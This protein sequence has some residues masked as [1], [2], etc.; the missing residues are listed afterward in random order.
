MQSPWEPHPDG[1]GQPSLQL[2]GST[3]QLQTDCL[4]PRIDCEQ[5]IYLQGTMTWIFRATLNA[6]KSFTMVR[7]VR[8]KCS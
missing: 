7:D 6:S 8:L 4:I 1:Q 3:L 2:K 5:I